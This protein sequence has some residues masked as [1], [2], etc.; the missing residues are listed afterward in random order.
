VK[1]DFNR[2]ISWNLLETRGGIEPPNKGFADL[3]PTAFI[4][5]ERQKGAQLPFLAWMKDAC[6]GEAVKVGVAAA[7]RAVA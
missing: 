5:G 3:C 4:F 7:K 2:F 6:N 1:D